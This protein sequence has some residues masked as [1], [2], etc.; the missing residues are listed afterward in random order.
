MILINVRDHG[1]TGD[2]VTNDA[3]A[4]RAA[5]AAAVKIGGA[6]LFPSGTY[7]IDP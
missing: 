4:I 2:G 5:I 7:R 3:P 6:V 1:A